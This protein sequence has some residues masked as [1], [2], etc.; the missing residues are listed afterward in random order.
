MFEFFKRLF[1]KVIPIAEGEP[2]QINITDSKIIINKNKL[3]LPCSVEKITAILGTPRAQRYETKN[4]DKNFLQKMHNNASV[5]DRV[6]YMWDN[7]GIKCYTLDGKTV[8]TFGVELNKG[9]LDYPNVPKSL[10]GGVITIKG[11]PWLSAIKSGSDEMVLQ[12]L[13]VGSFSLCAEYVD[14]DCDMNLRT[15]KDYTGIEI[16]L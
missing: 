4:E 8:H 6:N 2:V 5:T 3:S 14:I 12:K 13:K 15:E 10:F 11:Q 1:D 16:S 7:L 9:V